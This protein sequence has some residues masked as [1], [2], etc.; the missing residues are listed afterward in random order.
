VTDRR[1]RICDA[2]IAVLGTGG[3]RALTHRAVDAA[4]GLPQGSASNL[5]RTRYALLS[6]VLDRL[7][8]RET[9]RWARLTTAGMPRD[10]DTFARLLGTLVD[11]LTGPQRELTLARQAIFQE[12]AFRPDLQHRIATAERELVGW[13]SGWLAAL[14]STDPARDLRALLALIDGILMLRMANPADAPD[15][16]PMFAALLR[17]LRADGYDR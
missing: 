7:L 11:E 13:G 15:P 17:G 9:D 10:V 3:S 16:A 6:G 4:A 1:T 12:A 14:G 2:A 5:Y 8:E